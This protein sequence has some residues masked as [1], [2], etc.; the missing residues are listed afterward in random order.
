MRRLL[1]VSLISLAFLG[2][3][4]LAEAV[5]DVLVVRYR[6]AVPGLV[7]PLRLVQLSDSHA[8][9]INM[10]PVRLRR[11][12]AAINASHPD[13]VVLTGDNTSGFIF[14]WPHMWLSPALAPFSL[15]RAP[16]GVVA[17]PG[18]HDNPYWTR[19]FMAR[20]PVKLLA[21]T[22]VDVGPLV[23]AGAESMATPPDPLGNLA[24]AIARVPPGKPVI[25]LAHEPYA[26]ATLPARAALLIAGHTHGGQIRLPLLGTRRTDAYFDS[27]L[28]GVYREHGQVMI[29]SSG[30]GTSILPLRIGVPPEIVEIELVPV[31]QRAVPSAA[32][33][34]AAGNAATTSPL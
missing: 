15:L 13:L 24:R 32:A 4:G 27:H 20:G 21:G 16:L 23:L 14:T 26:F 30:A 2:L 34:A 3:Y 12:V 28:R 8:N 22:T 11:I 33:P 6:V 5:Q 1:F 29:V 7:A 31:S 25:A 19:I 18:N 17:V 10:P 9:W